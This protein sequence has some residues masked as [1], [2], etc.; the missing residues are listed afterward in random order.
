MS[1]EDD[2]YK[3]LLREQAELHA[4]HAVLQQHPNDHHGHQVHMA[5]LH[6]HIDRLRA[7]IAKLRDAKEEPR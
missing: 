7:H 4:E 1:A 5:R 2:D 6:A 3:A